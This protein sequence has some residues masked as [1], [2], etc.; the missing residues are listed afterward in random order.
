M[1][2]RFARY[3]PLTVFAA[4]LGIDAQ[5]LDESAAPPRYNI[6]P[7]TRAWVFAQD[8][9]GEPVFTV[10]PWHFPTS[11]G[12]RINVRSETAHVVPEY[13]EP[14][15]RHRCLVLASGFYEPEGAKTAKNRP[16]W[17]FQ[18]KGAAPLFLGA[19]AQPAG[20]A[21]LTR[22]PVDPVAQVHDRSP[23]QVPADQAMVWI[24]PEIEGRQ[25]LAQV[26]AG[27]ASAIEGWRVGNAAKRVAQDGVD[28]I[29]PVAASS[30]LFG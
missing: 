26:R 24:D 9:D 22:A 17:Y 2:G 16:W 4:A 15:N 10:M 19:V 12:N 3:Q 1:C 5:L 25:A 6:P 7:G 29:A 11:R 8:P 18:A 14:F 20:F 21:I 23:V 28:C 27:V 30:G 13:R